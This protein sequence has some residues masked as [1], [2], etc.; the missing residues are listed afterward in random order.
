MDPSMNAGMNAGMDSGL[1]SMVPSA[2]MLVAH[3][4][5][6]TLLAWAFTSTERSW[7]VTRRLLDAGVT[8]PLAVILDQL[9]G[10]L[11]ALAAA[12]ITPAQ[13]ADPPA[14]APSPDPG[15]NVWSR[16]ISVRR[17]PPLLLG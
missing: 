9:A 4:V 3:M 16:P 17:G 10:G 6:A 13:I 14:L 11:R 8:R 7:Q 15:R 1:T 5:A 2:P 12:C